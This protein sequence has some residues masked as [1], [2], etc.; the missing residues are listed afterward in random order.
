MTKPKPLNKA[1]ASW[2]ILALAFGPTTT[3]AQVGGVITTPTTPMELPIE[4]EIELSPAGSLKQALLWKELVQLL[5]NPYDPV[6]RRP[7][8]GVAMPPVNMY[9]LNYNFL[10]GQPLRLRTSDGEVSWD[11][12]G[13]MFGTAEVVPLDAFNSPTASG[14]SIGVVVVVITPPT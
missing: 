7:G 9:P 11:Q 6:V 1:I 5:E 10:T 3:I 4:V 8:F 13:P 12:P 14:S 2:L